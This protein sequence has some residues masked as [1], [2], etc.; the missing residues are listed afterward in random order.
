MRMVR[1]KGARW[2]LTGLLIDFQTMTVSGLPVERKKRK[3]D[4]RREEDKMIKQSIHH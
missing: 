2:W 1:M 3:E 4:K